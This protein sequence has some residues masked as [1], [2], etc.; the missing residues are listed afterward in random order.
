MKRFKLIG[1][2]VLTLVGCR[3]QDTLTLPP[4][5]SGATL[6]LA[7][8]TTSAQGTQAASQIL[9]TRELTAT[10]TQLFKNIG[11][12]SLSVMTPALLN[13]NTDISCSDGGTFRYSGTYSSS[14]QSYALSLTFNGCRDKGYQYVGDTTVNGTTADFVVALGGSS[15]FN[16]FN[17]NTAYTVLLAYLKTNLSFTMVGS[18]TATDATYTI[19]V[20]G[21]ITSF[22][23]FLLNTYSMTFSG[24]NSTY[25]LATNATTTDQTTTISTNG[26]FR[27]DWGGTNYV[28]IRATDFTVSRTQYFDAGSGTYASESTGLTGTVVYTFRPAMFG[29]SGLFNVTTQTPV[30]TVYSPQRQTTQGTLIINGTATAQYNAGGDMTVSVAGGAPVNYTTEYELMKTTDFA[31]MEQDKPPLI[32]PPAPGVVST[33]TGSSMGV[34]LTW[35]GPAPTYSSLSDMDLH[36]KYYAVS[37]PTGTTAETWHI[38]WHQGVSC[39]N[40][41]GLAFGNAGFDLDGNGIC[42]AGLDFDDVDGYGPEHI[43]ALKVLPGYYVISVDSYSLHGDASASLYLSVNIGD[44]IFGAY[45]GTLSASDGETA[46]ASAW[47]RVADVRVNANGTV[48]VLYPDP[49]LTPWH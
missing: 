46:A 41:P 35:T 38:D 37:A 24:L 31:A 43:T 49:A 48:D 3:V 19:N 36:M 40:P 17:F 32:T 25:T 22:D 10:S 8:V 23:Y 1:V 11:D 28:I 14:N 18:G 33:V 45:L 39:T 30:N 9:Q 15:T 29:F 26:Q 2:L 4:A 42:D 34:T 6:T 7:S 44:N 47:L 16:I 5:S 13:Q 27:E 21:T 20:N 12:I